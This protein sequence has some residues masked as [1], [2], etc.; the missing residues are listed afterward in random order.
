LVIVFAFLCFQP[1]FK[2][3]QPVGRYELLKTIG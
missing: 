1:C 2:C 3:F